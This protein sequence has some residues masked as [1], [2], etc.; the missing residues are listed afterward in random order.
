MK[1]Y[2]RKRL[3]IGILSLSGVMILTVV[4]MSLFSSTIVD[5]SEENNQ[6][7]PGI[8]HGYNYSNESD[9]LSNEQ[10]LMNEIW[11]LWVRNT[12]DNT[13]ESLGNVKIRAYC[14][15]DITWG[16]E[17]S[18]QDDKNYVW[19]LG[20]IDEG[21]QI[22]FGATIEQAGPFNPDVEL[23]RAVV[24]PVLKWEETLQ[25][26]NFAVIFNSFPGEELNIVVA[27]RQFEDDDDLIMT[28]IISQNDV[29]GWEK[30]IISGV[31][32]WLT[33]RESI[34][35]GVPHNFVAE[36]KSI[37]SPLIEGDPVYKPQVSV[38]MSHPHWTPG[39]VITNSYP[40]SHPD[41]IDVIFETDNFIEWMPGIRS[42]KIIYLS[43][44]ESGLIYCPNG[45]YYVSEDRDGDG[46]PDEEDNCPFTPNPEQEDSD[47][48]GI[49][50]SCDVGGVDIDIKPGSYPNS[51]NLK[52]KGVIQVAILTTDTLDATTVNSASVRFGATGTE[53]VPVHFALED[54]DGDGDFDMILHFRTNETGIQCEDTFAFL[55]GATFSLQAIQGTDSIKTVGCREQKKK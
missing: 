3:N 44:I 4:L 23:T 48:D 52:S 12:I 28:E 24:P 14:P 10:V 8:L 6:A 22:G 11:I 25:V 31:A 42:S 41:G 27:I 46:I 16:T 39:P 32:Q 30:K 43:K 35:L 37:K 21:D 53:A 7:Q 19:E 34:T 26:I 9:V 38:E 17:P 50:D 45:Q 29:P 1:F 5:T 49:G 36:V 2:K 47:G 15:F 18:S 13:G 20:D 55:V 54:V 40:I 33:S 51:I